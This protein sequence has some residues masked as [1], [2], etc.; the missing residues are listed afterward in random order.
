MSSKNNPKG[1]QIYEERVR[2]RMA[3]RLTNENL[4]KVERALGYSFKNK[5]LLRQA[6]L[7]SYIH[8]LSFDLKVYEAGNDT[9]EFIGDRI[10]YS[11]LT[12]L[13][14]ITYKTESTEGYVYLPTAE[15][16]T[17]FDLGYTTNSYWTKIMNLPKNK[18]MKE[19]IVAYNNN[20]PKDCKVWADLLEAIFG[21]IALDSDYNMD[22]LRKSFLY[23]RFRPNNMGL[24]NKCKFEEC[25]KNKDVLADLTSRLKDFGYD[26]G[27]TSWMK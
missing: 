17:N 10:L 1:P 21:A 25:L 2:A 13:F 7:K 20:F 12:N 15:Q 26:F 22:Y 19:L 18:F 27:G 11:V 24:L 23:L 5:N 14:F 16:I 4:M 6:F 8:V 9:F 3:E